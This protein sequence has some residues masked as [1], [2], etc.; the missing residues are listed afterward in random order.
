MCKYFRGVLHYTFLAFEHIIW[1]TQKTNKNGAQVGEVGDRNMTYV[2][3]MSEEITS[4]IFS[5]K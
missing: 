3:V 1:N 4:K 2:S 5:A